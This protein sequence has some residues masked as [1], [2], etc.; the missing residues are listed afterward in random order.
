MSVNIA[1]KSPVQYINLMMFSL[2]FMGLFL[3]EPLKAETQNPYQ[4]NYQQQ[5]NNQLKSQQAKP[6]TQ[7]EIKNQKI[8][9]NSIDKDNI[10]MLEDG[11]DMQG[12]SGFSANEAPESL[13]L[14]HG[15]N[16]KAD[17]VL[18]YVNRG[19]ED[20]KSTSN[21]TSAEEPKLHYFYASYWVAVPMPTLGVHVVKLKKLLTNRQ[22]AEASGGE[23][24]EEPGLKVIAVI[25]E[26]AAAR[27][28][29]VRGDVILS[30][31]D[32]IVNQQSELIAAVKR[33]KGQSTPAT[34][35]RN[36][37]KKEVQLFLNS[38]AL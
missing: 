5:N 8:K 16:I 14:A 22:A 17:K 20:A 4:E 37:D 12:W 3:A 36:G 27:S 34:I 19:D 23:V 21:E 38:T 30:V 31:G 9:D 24:P 6:D 29:L 10:S 7:L 18:L 11:F 33:Y 1:Q 2:F 15:K 32:A 13:A 35:V 26:S 28:G 25:K